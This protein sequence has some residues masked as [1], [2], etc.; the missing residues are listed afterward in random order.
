[1]APGP[2]TTAG[3]PVIGAPQV[4]QSACRIAGTIHGSL[5]HGCQQAQLTIYPERHRAAGHARVNAREGP[6]VAKVPSG[7]DGREHAEEPGDGLGRSAW[8]TLVV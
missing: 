7:D 1:M 3:R 5:L 2:T 8:S 4:R 6:E